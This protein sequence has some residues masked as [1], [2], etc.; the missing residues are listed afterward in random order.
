MARD[1]SELL[2]D[3]LLLPMEARAALIDTLIGSLDSI[4][5]ADAEESWREEIRQRI[6]QIDSGAV[7]LVTWEKARRQLRAGMSR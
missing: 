6:E 4:I 3:A 5:D 1:T 7:Q 2:K